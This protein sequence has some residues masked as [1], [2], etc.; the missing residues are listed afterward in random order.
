MAVNLATKYEK[1]FAA[2][3]KPN[4]YFEGKT[5]K[6]YTF[7]GA[8]TIRIYSPVTAEL[9]DITETVQTDTEH[10]RKWIQ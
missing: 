3:F 1:Q 5:N 6:K 4:S 9:V 2:A 10:L 8:K 7:D